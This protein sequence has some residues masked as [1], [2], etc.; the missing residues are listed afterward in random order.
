MQRSRQWYSG[1]HNNFAPRFGITWAP[2]RDRRTAIRAN[3]GIFYERPV[4][5]TAT[6]ADN[7]SLGSRRR[8]P[9]PSER[10][11]RSHQ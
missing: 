5:S 4:G 9:E 8:S 7:F 3:Y 6:V 11:G 10:I 2:G 1:D